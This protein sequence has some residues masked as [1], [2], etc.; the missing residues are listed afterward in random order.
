MSKVKSITLRL[1]ILPGSDFQKTVAQ[2]YLE[3]IAKAT[4]QYFTN[5]HKGNKVKW[6]LQTLFKTAEGRE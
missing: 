5:A 3:Q 1:K 4:E 2:G 6:E